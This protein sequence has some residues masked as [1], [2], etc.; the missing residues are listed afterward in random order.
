[1]EV[2][3]SEDQVKEQVKRDRSPSF[4]YLGLGKALERIEVLFEKTK[5]H[6]ARVAD[7]AKDWG[8]APRSSSTDR[9]VAALLAYGLV[10]DAGGGE[11]RKIKISERGW[12]IL[13]DKRPGV[14]EKLLA[15][16]ALTP[17][18]IAEYAEKWA[19]GR[20]DESHALSQLKFE[21][22]FT[23]DGARLFLRVFDET[24]RFTG[25]RDPDKLPDTDSD[26]GNTPTRAKVGDFV[27][28][29]SG[30]IEQFKPPR[31]VISVSEDGQWLWVEDSQTGIPM[32]EVQIV[33]A[34]T[35]L[36]PPPPPAEVVASIAAR[37]SAIASPK[38]GTQRDMF[39]LDE[40]VVT[41]E[42]P[43]GLKAESVD[44]LEEFL[45]LF[46]KKARRRA[47]A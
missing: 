31:Q 44:E 25:D 35:G 7:I 42:F 13:D 28:W 9:N 32:T 11:N 21:G 36:T 39:S 6:D 1:M 4:P 38:P 14:R 24:I 23:D 8:L 41:L 45:Q 16:A 17:R 3:V 40:G 20:P 2:S 37:A 27:Q 29:T 12:R 19:G 18:I 46:I 26:K 34:P 22:G 15:E 30:G 33:T 10:D 47:K 5:R 43:E